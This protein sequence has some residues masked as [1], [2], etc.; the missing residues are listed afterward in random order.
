MY[1]ERDISIDFLGIRLDSPFILSAAPSTDE[2]ELAYDGLKEGWAGV[3]LKTTSVE[4]NPVPLKYPMMSSFGPQSRKVTGLGNIDLISQ[5]HIDVIEK[6]VKA[7]KESFPHKMI[8]ASI[9][10]AKKEDW[11]SLVHRLKKAGVDIIECSFSCPQGSMGEA[12]GRMLAQ[13]V[14]ATEKVA[15]WVKEAAGDTPVLIKI[16]PQVTDIVEVARAVKRG[17]ADGITASNTIPSLLGLDIYTFEPYPSLFGKGGYS[18]LSGSAIKPITL[19]TIAEI[20]RNVDI[21]ISGNGGAFNWKDAVEFMAVGAG[22]VQFCT[23][24]MHYG[25]RTIRDL[26]SGLAGYLDAMGFKSPA[27]IVK[28]ALKNIYSHEEIPAPKTR[29]Q[30]IEEKCVGCG[31]CYVACRD[32]GHRAIEWRSGNVPGQDD[33]RKPAFDEEKCPGCAMCMQVCPVDAIRM[34]EQMDGRCQYYEEVR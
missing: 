32:G 4:E 23:L 21:V 31:L 9:M 24:P 1:R 34:K 7:L 20:A 16:T 12:P 14:E 6:R 13:S 3:I 29:A 33:S 30:L 2:L 26:K 28:K 10:G 19:R 22:N 15:G 18:G 25:F 17:G 5:Y 11:Q 27:D 8:G